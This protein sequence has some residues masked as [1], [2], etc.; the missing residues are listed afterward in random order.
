MK[1][2]VSYELSKPIQIRFRTRFLLFGAT[3]GAAGKKQLIDNSKARE[4][5]PQAR[6]KTLQARTNPSQA[7][8]NL[9]P[10][11]GWTSCPEDHS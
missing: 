4:Y 1:A 9:K 5:V 11:K 10:M 7:I 8:K 6:K 2:S 3:V